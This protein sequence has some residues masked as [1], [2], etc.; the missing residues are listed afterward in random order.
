MPMIQ[1]T[2]PAGA[3]SERRE[4]GLVADATT[5]V[6]EAAGLTA[7]DA[8]SVWALTHEQPEGTWGAGGQVVRYA[9]LVAR[10]QTQRSTD[11]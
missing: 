10:A 3:L 5:A 2:A 4:V 11:A 9:D 1:L 8:P 6:L 7:T